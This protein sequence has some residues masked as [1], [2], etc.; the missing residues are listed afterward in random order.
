MQMLTNP[1]SVLYRTDVQSAGLTMRKRAATAFVLVLLSGCAAQ[2]RITYDTTDVRLLGNGPLGAYRL[3][4][5]QFEEGRDADATTRRGDRFAAAQTEREGETWYTNSDDHYESPVCPAI[6]TMVA[7]H[8]RA[9]HLFRDVMVSEDAATPSDLILRGRI[10]QFDAFRMQRPVVE[11][12][13]AQPGLLWLIIGW[14]VKTQYKATT[15]LTDVRLDDAEGAPLWH[16]DIDGG[17]DGKDSVI[18]GQWAVYQEANL[19]LK[20][21]TDKL[22][23]MLATVK[24]PPTIADR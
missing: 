5:R 23:A 2:Q 7:N 21:A 1:G 8:L 18:N 4:V 15:V 16:G 13:V 9:S 24:P 17:V 6:T 14:A 12:F 20:A 22:L 11:G 19:A 3:L 10:R